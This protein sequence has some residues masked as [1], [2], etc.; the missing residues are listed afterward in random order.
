MQF[1]VIAH[2]TTR[3]GC[4][5]ELELR[6]YPPRF[7]RLPLTLGHISFSIEMQT[8]PSYATREFELEYIRNSPNNWEP[9][10]AFYLEKR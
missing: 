1:P 6:F 2:M 3:C 8:Q 10:H 9:T 5:Q 4:K 7:L